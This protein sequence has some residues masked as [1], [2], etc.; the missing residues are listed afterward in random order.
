MRQQVNRKLIF[1]CALLLGIMVFE[2]TWQVVSRYIFNAPSGWTDEILRFQLIWLTMIGAPL[3]HGMNRIM[4]VTVF[5]DRMNESKKRINKIVVEFIILIFAILV[6]V[7]GGFMV[8]TNAYGQ[9]SA[10][11]GINMFYVY[12]SIPV[13]GF[14]FIFY[15]VL[16]LKEFIGKKEE[17]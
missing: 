6:L 4:A 15:N 1:I 14:L 9:I 12:L 2:A 11:L 3:A 5:V 7:V 8:A 16:N 17:K 13:S 10:S